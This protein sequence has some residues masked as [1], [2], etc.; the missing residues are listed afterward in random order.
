MESLKIN[1]WPES[2]RPCSFMQNLHT[3]ITSDRSSTEQLTSLVRFGQRFGELHGPLSLALCFFG[4]PTNVANILVLTRTSMSQSAT[5][6]LLFWLAVADLITMLLY[7]PSLYHFYIVRPNP[8][9]SPVYSPYKLWVI[10]QTAAASGL[11]I[12]HSLALWIAVVLAVFR[13]LYI[14]FPTVGPR[15]ATKRRAFLSVIVLALGCILFV[16]PNALINYV[17]RCYGTTWIM[18]HT[19][20]SNSDKFDVYYSVGFESN[21]E[22][23]MS[24]DAVWPKKEL[25]AVNTWLQASLFKIFPCFLLSVLTVLLVFQMKKAI[26]RRKALQQVAARQQVTQLLKNNQKC[27]RNQLHSENRTTTLLLAILLTVLIVEL[28]QGILVLCLQLIEN[29][30]VN[31][32]QHLG[33]FIDFT[34][35]VNESMNFVIYTSMSHQFRREFCQLFLIDKFRERFRRTCFATESQTV[36]TNENASNVKR[37]DISNYVCCMPRSSSTDGQPL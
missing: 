30:Y 33:D 13:Y 3:N 6:H 5:N 34:T 7:V 14:G 10:Y 20:E 29:F 25:Y 21:D 26:R 23:N 8:I 24:S 31:V 4:I 9:R 12:F 32:Y 2:I 19:N 11:I 18:F 28:P 36:E 22:Q 35:L 17:D 27:S 15:L 16:I 37:A 1:G